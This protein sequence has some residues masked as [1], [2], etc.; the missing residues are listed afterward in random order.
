MERPRTMF[1]SRE[2]EDSRGYSCFILPNITDT[3]DSPQVLFC[4]RIRKRMSRLVAGETGYQ[5]VE[6]KS[7]TASI[8][9]EAGEEG[10]MSHASQQLASLSISKASNLADEIAKIEDYVPK[11]SKQAKVDVTTAIALW[12]SNPKL[13]I[14]LEREKSAIRRRTE[15]TIAIFEHRSEAAIS[16]KTFTFFTKL[17]IELRRMIWKHVAT[18]ERVVEMM[19][20]PSTHN[21]NRHA[22]NRV[23]ERACVLVSDT[24]VPAML[25]ASWESRAVGLE[26]YGRVS[27]YR[28]DKNK[29]KN[30]RITFVNWNADVLLVRHIESLAIFLSSQRKPHGILSAITT[31]C[32]K[33][34]APYDHYHIFREGII[35][36]FRFQKIEELYIMGFD[37]PY[38]GATGKISLSLTADETS[39]MHEFM[40][41]G[42][43][44]SVMKD[45]K[46][47]KYTGVR[48]ATREEEGGEDEQV[49]KKRIAARQYDSD[50]L[51]AAQ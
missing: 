17:P 51:M 49:R 10:G 32:K 38:R 29:R 30:F 19:L 40:N 41:F 48:L 34:A 7:E 25:H 45:H 16:G 33:L 4:H 44:E 42:G 18:E 24:V 14:Q 2:L 1:P 36:G 50:L 9:E 46:T 22:I 31:S 20:V 5:I 6:S 8:I 28:Y 15:A 39:V 43:I 23:G 35:N 47:L 11:T 37:K 27:E 21:P 26:V 13:Y 3:R 12:K